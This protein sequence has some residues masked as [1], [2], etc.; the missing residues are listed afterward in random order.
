[1]ELFAIIVMSISI[2]FITS[3]IAWAFF[4]FGALTLGILLFNAALKA[5][6]KKKG[7]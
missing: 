1:M 5:Y 7:S 6:F 3:S 4:M 2:G